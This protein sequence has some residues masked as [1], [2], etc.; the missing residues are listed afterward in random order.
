MAL[1]EANHLTKQFGGLTVVND[2][3]FKVEE[4]KITG[5]IGP[6]GAGKTTT[7]NL[8]TGFLA[9]TSGKV[10]YEGMDITGVPATKL[11]SRHITRAFQIPHLF[12]DLSVLENV[13]AGFYSQTTTGTI[14]AMFRL[15]NVKKEERFA[16]EKGM[17]ILKNL[18]MADLADMQARMLST[19]Q[20]KM[21]E[22]ARALATNPKL[23]M[24]DEPAAGLDTAETDVLGKMVKQF[25]QQGIT[26]LMIEHNMKF[27]MEFADY[28]YVLNFG[29]LLAE[30]T[31]QEIMN[32]DEV[33]KACLGKEFQKDA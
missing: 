32:N 20:Q 1:L 11:V 19:G 14:S 10:L 13:M 31:P 27:M 15:P 12:N 3:T 2:V 23:L 29:Q 6:N 25:N 17:E 7:F 26:V 18:G 33:A 28:I 5:L 21:L 22:I 8:V 24:L 16:R 4:G 9:L 30:G